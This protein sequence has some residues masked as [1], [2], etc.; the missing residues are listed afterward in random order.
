[1]STTDLILG[2]LEAHL[3]AQSPAPD[4]VQWNDGDAFPKTSLVNEI[5]ANFRVLDDDIIQAPTCGNLKGSR[6]IVVRG[7]QGDQGGDESLDF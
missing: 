1:M 5:L 3:G 2:Q 4:T 6:L 7:L